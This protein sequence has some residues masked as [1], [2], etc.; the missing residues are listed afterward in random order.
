MFEVAP[1]GVEAASDEQKSTGKTLPVAGLSEDST[2][3]RTTGT[4]KRI[5]YQM[6]EEVSYRD[7][8]NVNR[9]CHTHGSSYST[10]QTGA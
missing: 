1:G 6:G 9:P 8:F 3:S 7:I 10:L 4:L 5:S 2:Q